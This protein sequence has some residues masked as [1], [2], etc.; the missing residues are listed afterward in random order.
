M[1]PISLLYALFLSWFSPIQGSS[2]VTPV[3]VQKGKDVLL[4]VKTD[5]GLQEDVFVSWTYNAH[6]V[7]VRSS[8]QKEPKIY[9]NYTGRIEFSVKNY[10]LTLKNLQE[11]DDGVYTVRMIG[12]IEVTAQYIVRVQDPVSPVNLTVDSVSNSS[13]SCNLTVACRTQDSL[14]SSTFRCDTKSCSE[15]GGERSEVMTSGASLHVYLVNDSIICNHSNQVSWTE[16]IEMIEHFCPLSAVTAEQHNNTVYALGVVP[17]LTVIIAAAFYRHRQKSRSKNIE[18]TVYA[19]PK[20]T[21]ATQ[22]DQSPT[23]DTSG[24]SPMSTYCLVGHHTGSTGST[25]S[26]GNTQPESLYAKVEKPARS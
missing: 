18:N 3:F 22:M 7:I 12:D 26:G 25:K 17:I 24:A 19:D 21:A 15:E 1:G 23:N 6:N 10:S 14:I 8:S 13:D 9:L 11:A 4:N 20:V 5:D 2:A 16:D